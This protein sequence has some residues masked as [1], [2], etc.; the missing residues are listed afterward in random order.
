MTDWL[1]SIPIR[2]QRTAQQQEISK[3][4]ARFEPVRWQL[5][6]TFRAL[7]IF[8]TSFFCWTSQELSAGGGRKETN[9]IKWL[10][11]SGSSVSERV[12]KEIHWKCWAQTLCSELSLFIIK[13]QSLVT[14]LHTQHACW[15]DDKTVHLY[16]DLLLVHTDWR[17]ATRP[18]IFE[19]G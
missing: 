19:T 15:S 16:G 7:P 14:R 12:P 9:N 8:K 13:A 1:P 2:V 4:P 6:A 18:P 11:A 10:P 17:T 5:K 3:W